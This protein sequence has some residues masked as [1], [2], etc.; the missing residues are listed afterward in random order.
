MMRCGKRFQRITAAVVGAHNDKWEVD[1]CGGH[2]FQD[3]DMILAGF[4]GTDRQHILGWKPVFFLHGGT[5]VRRSFPQKHRVT[6]LIN[7]Y[8]FFFRNVRQLHQIT[9]RLFTHRNDFVGAGTASQI[10]F[11][12]EKAVN[13]RIEFGELEKNQVVHSQDGFHARSFDADGKFVRQTVKNV[14]V[15]FLRFGCKTEGSPQR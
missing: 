1:L 15:P 7:H 12:I 8:D 4:E 5:L 6:A 13:S 14:Q 10:F 2:C 9:A 11:L 3:K